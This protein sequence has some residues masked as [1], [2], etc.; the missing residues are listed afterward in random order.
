MIT[1][2]NNMICNRCGKPNEPGNAFCQ[3]CGSPLSIDAPD[4]SEEQP[5]SEPEGS[6]PTQTAAAPSIIVPSVQQPRKKKANIP[7]IIMGAVSVILAVII[8]LMACGVTDAVFS[9]NKSF[10]EPEDAI[11]YFFERVKA[12]DFDGA[13]SVCAADEVSEKYDF[14]AMLDRLKALTPSMQ[15]LP[16]EYKLYSAFDK[17]SVKSQIMRQLSYMALSSVLPDKYAGYLNGTVISGKDFDFDSV[18]KD[19]DPKDFMSLEVA[20]IGQNGRMKDSNY[21]DNMKKQAKVYGAD[22]ITARDILF[23]IGGKYYAGGVMLIRYGGGWMIGQLNDPLINQSV[24]GALIPLDSKSDFD[25]IIS[26]GEAP[27]VSEAPAASVAASIAPS[28]APATPAPAESLSIGV[29]LIGGATDTY[30]ILQSGD[31]IDAAISSGASVTC[32]FAN[33]DTATQTSQLEMFITSGVDVLAVEPLDYNALAST[34]QKAKSAGIKVILIGEDFSGTLSGLYDTCITYDYYEVSYELAQWMAAN[35]G[36]SLNIAGLIAVHST[37]PD[38]RAQALS[39]AASSNPGWKIVDTVAV[40]YDKT[41][42]IDETKAL[43]K[44]HPD[45]NVLF[46][47][48]DNIALG[49]VQAVEEM[50]LTDKV[51]VVGMGFSQEAINAVAAGKLG[52]FSVMDLHIGEVLNDLAGKLMS[53]ESVAAKN[54]LPPIIVDIN[55]AGSMQNFGY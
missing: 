21:K 3:Y 4:V 25:D 11:K 35:L 53:G 19:M 22:E 5:H 38:L 18:V 9:A 47:N 13:L 12:G 41:K 49:A 54:T 15:Y 42:A 32:E 46:C 7:A 2:E 43:L 17:V 6:I 10:A 31:I 20:D 45:I 51:K 24:T 48:S 23:K 28:V 16:A 36:S 8:V 50:K 1:E 30:S 34:L 33:Y 26:T 39:D 52:A 29:S 44:K 37:L 14:G 55:N 27:Q 40:G